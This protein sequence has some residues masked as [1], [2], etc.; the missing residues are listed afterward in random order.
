ME[1]LRP[2]DPEQIGPWQIVNRL[3]SGG[4]GVV[5]MG[6]N[7]TRAAA[8][9]VLRDY[10]LDDP[11]SRTRLARE[12]EALERVKGNYAA[13]IVGADTDSN[14]A[15][16][17]TNYVDGPSL[18]TLVDREGPL[19]EKQWLE[20]AYGLMDALASIHAL[21]V[22]HRDIKPSNILIAKDGP[23]LI[24]FGISLS[25]DATSLTGTGLVAGTPSWLAPEQFLGKP[26]TTALDNFAAGS[27]LVFAATG[28]NPWDKDD[29]SVAAVMHSIINNKVDIKKLNPIQRSVCEKLLIKDPEQ[30]ATAAEIRN[31]ISSENKN[32]EQQDLQK[33]EN[34]KKIETRKREEDLRRQKAIQ[35]A[36]QKVVEKQLAESAKV[37]E[38]NRKAEEKRIKKEATKVAKQAKRE[39]VKSVDSI[40]KFDELTNLREKSEKRKFIGSSRKLR[41]FVLIIILVGVLGSV[42]YLG[43]GLFERSTGSDPETSPTNVETQKQPTI[44]V[45]KWEGL[46]EGE[47]EPQVGT[48]D[49]FIVFV[50]D[51]AV[52]RSTLIL[53]QIGG[54]RISDNIVVN[55]IRGDERCGEEFDTIEI[56]GTSNRKL[57]VGKYIVK[58][59]TS[60]NFSFEYIISIEF[61]GESINE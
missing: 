5:Y 55:L 59:E 11:T 33:I 28:G 29:S 20:F 61:L 37:A 42:G 31:Y 25:G 58:G 10:L 45:T 30:R 26:L 27:T 52:R 60:T 24:D 51:Q 36:N 6:T 9:K 34:Q 21:G 18:K 12:V 44:Q 49:E 16:I 56:K 15:W 19:N 38:K 43:Q 1:R 40:Q 13:E 14:P 23:K 7:G 47:L 17:A 4:M 48:G 54:N 32:A 41:R 57:G 53:E 50:C 22:I 46:I 3:G 8:I 35:D 2:G 39:Q